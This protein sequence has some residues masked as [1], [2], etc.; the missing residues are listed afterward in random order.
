MLSIPCLQLHV[1]TRRSSNRRAPCLRL[2]R[3]EN[4]ISA[5][6]LNYLVQTSADKSVLKGPPAHTDPGYRPDG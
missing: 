1:S 6:G 4:S 5:N 2:L 3:L